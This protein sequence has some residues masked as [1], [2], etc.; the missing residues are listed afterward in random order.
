MRLI[1]AETWI[2][3]LSNGFVTPNYHP[4]LGDAFQCMEA[5][6][7]NEEIYDL[8]TQINEQPTAFDI[9]EIL[10]QLENEKGD[11]V[12]YINPDGKRLIR[13]WNLC[14]DYCKEIIKAYIDKEPTK[15]Y[16]KERN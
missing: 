12:D 10:E 8:I 14:I 6:Q 2:E 1:D 9:E 3:K 15:S 7:H 11:E 13:H 4:D 5:E 16:E